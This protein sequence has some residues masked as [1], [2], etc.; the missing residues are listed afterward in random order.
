MVAATFTIYDGVV[1]TLAVASTG[2][3]STCANASVIITAV[4]ATD[5]WEALAQELAISAFESFASS[6]ISAGGCADCGSTSE[7]G[8]S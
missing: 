8:I 3:V 1:A 5:W 4:F 7:G 6:T 2:A